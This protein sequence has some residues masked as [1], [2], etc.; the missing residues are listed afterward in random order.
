VAIIIMERREHLATITLVPV[1]SQARKSLTYP[2]PSQ[3][4]ALVT[5][6][7]SKQGRSEPIR[8]GP[9]LLSLL[10]MPDFGIAL[11]SSNADAHP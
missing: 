2:T 5:V 1:D 6:F 8:A 9:R 3:T 4:T 7:G 10:P 11:P